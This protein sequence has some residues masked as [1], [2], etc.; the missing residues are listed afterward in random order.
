M[1][2]IATNRVA[3]FHLSFFR[4][5]CDYLA[6]PTTSFFLLCVLATWQHRASRVKS[7]DGATSMAAALA[8]EAVTAPDDAPLQPRQRFSDYMAL[9]CISDNTSSQPRQSFNDPPTSAALQHR[10]SPMSIRRVAQEFYP[11]QPHRA[12]SCCTTSLA[13]V[14]SMP[15]PAA[16]VLVVVFSNAS[17]GSSP[18]A[19][20][21]IISARLQ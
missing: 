8:C 6:G 17:R 2:L 7:F 5:S 14:A 10:W 20:E 12:P 3:V 18:V 9:H 1:R 4:P 11:L 13:N 21:C 15:S 16:L 19:Q